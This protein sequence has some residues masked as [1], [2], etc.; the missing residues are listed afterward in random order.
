MMGLFPYS[1]TAVVISS[2]EDAEAMVELDPFGV[3][4]N[5]Y[6]SSAYSV[7]FSLT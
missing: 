6:I 3:V 4:L 5:N 1:A 2:H 7:T